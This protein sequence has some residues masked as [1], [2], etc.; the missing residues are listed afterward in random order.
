MM[1]MM[2][3]LC[4]AL[5][6]PASLSSLLPCVHLSPCAVLCCCACCGYLQLSPNTEHSLSFSTQ[7]LSSAPPPAQLQTGGHTRRRGA[8][9]RGAWALRGV[10]GGVNT[11]LGLFTGF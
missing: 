1:M 10:L 6:A 4:L 2:T 7:Q 9:C 5:M 3:H 8:G 11:C